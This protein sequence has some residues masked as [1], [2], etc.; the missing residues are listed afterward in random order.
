MT[1]NRRLQVE[2]EDRVWKFKCD[3]ESEVSEWLQAVNH[4]VRMT[5]Y[6]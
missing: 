6:E 1:N 2:T 4:V 5:D 3:K